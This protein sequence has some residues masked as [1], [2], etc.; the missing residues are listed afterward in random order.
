MGVSFTLGVLMFL[1]MF[2]EVDHYI[3]H[4]VW[5]DSL[6]DDE[7]DIK[8]FAAR[9]GWSGEA[10]RTLNSHI[11]EAKRTMMSDAVDPAPTRSS[12]RPPSRVCCWPPAVA[13]WCS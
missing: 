5:S 2:P 10:I 9:M 12:A 8:R 4:S 11:H 7:K 1:K 13:R 6:E 3:H